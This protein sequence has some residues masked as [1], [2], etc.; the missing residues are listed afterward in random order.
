MY[1]SYF[2]F[3]ERPFNITSNP[4]FFYSNPAYQKAYSNLLSGIR[5][6]R[7][8]MVLTGE[9]GTGKTTLLRKLINDADG[10]IHYIISYNTTLPF[11]DLLGFVCENLGLEVNEAESLQKIQILGEFLTAQRQ[12]GSTVALLIDDAHNLSDEVLE[13][14]LLLAK[15]WTHGE[16]LL[17]LVLCGLPELETKLKQS[18]L[19]PFES[20]IAVRCQLD[21][22]NN[23]EVGAFINQRLH[24]VGFEGEDL[25]SPGAVQRIALY[26]KGIPRLIDALC[27]SAL[28]TASLGSQ[29][30]ITAEIVEEAAQYCSLSLRREIPVPS[31]K[32][33]RQKSSEEEPSAS[34]EQT[35]LEQTV[36][37]GLEVADDELPPTVVLH[38][39]PEVEAT[40]PDLETAIR[41]DDAATEQVRAPSY[42]RPRGRGAITAGVLALFF[43]GIAIA[44][45]YRAEFT[46]PPTRP[47]VAATADGTEANRNA[48]GS[49]LEDILPGEDELMAERTPAGSQTPPTTETLPQRE[50]EIAT[51]PPAPV[52][53]QASPAERPNE[54]WVTPRALAPQETAQQEPHEA[55]PPETTDPTGVRSQPLERS[56]EPVPSSL[57]VDE[58]IVDGTPLTG[59][60]SAAS[61]PIDAQ[62]AEEKKTDRETLAA[63]PAPQQPAERTLSREPTRQK[64]VPKKLEVAKKAPAT[65]RALRLPMSAGP[66][67]RAKP[68][69]LAETQYALRTDHEV[70]PLDPRHKKARTQL[71]QVGIPFTRESLL[72]RAAQGDVDKVAL[73]LTAGISPNNAKDP[74]GKTPLMWAVDK[75]H[76]ETVQ[77][78]LARGAVVNAR[79]NK[80]ETALMYAAWNG[81]ARLVQ[82]LLDKGA[83]VNAKNHDGWTALIDAGIGGHTA[84]VQALLARHAN[85]NAKNSEGR[86]AL[87]AA[88]WNGHSATAQALLGSGADVNGQNKDG[89][90]A[91]MF[92]AWN[93]HTALVKTLLEN[94]ADTNGK[95]RDG[96]TPL[97]LA[98]S[99][100]HTQ[101]VKL[102]R[103]ARGEESAAR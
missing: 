59:P 72:E 94:S 82:V 5:E 26:A 42:R 50:D 80:G 90:T 38:N 39:V 52:L 55:E 2:G 49:L 100:G 34:L 58:R 20:R 45:F 31:R 19:K 11:D 76:T 44:V 89:W 54:E 69:P 7:G 64:P 63:P 86:T 47:P 43:I 22:L 98:T 10:T 51:Q 24:A 18:S 35:V 83:A 62:P 23:E 87:M 92:A 15:A 12:T 37:R 60:Q 13:S 57:S 85:P 73:L 25:F 88:A 68:R 21:P 36:R 29:R 97:M 99:Q 30:T 48:A 77:L 32:T 4:R 75:G 102:L 40:I 101:V 16:S 3:R 79:N 17:Q 66:R 33:H 53:S 81:D 41:P 78:L 1:T 103:E 93:G 95:N 65:P 84:V 14:L 96:E 27:G 28:H 61:Q 9:V 71:Q 8:I 46:S 67:L 6:H 70:L 74:Q 91:L 56:L